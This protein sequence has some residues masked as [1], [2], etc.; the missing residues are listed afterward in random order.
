MCVLQNYTKPQPIISNVT[1]AE[2][3]PIADFY[4]ISYTY[5]SCLGFAGVLVVGIIVSLASCKYI[6]IIKYTNFRVAITNSFCF[7]SSG[8][9][10]KIRMR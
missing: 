9:C 4:S 6:R 1:Q 7:C 8:S 2:L 5:Y 10:T 3:P